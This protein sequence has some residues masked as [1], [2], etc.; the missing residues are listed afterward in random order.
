M[1]CNRS[2]WP[3]WPRGS[4]STAAIAHARARCVILAHRCALAGRHVSCRSNAGP[5]SRS[6][7]MSGRGVRSSLPANFGLNDERR[8]SRLRPMRSPSASGP[9]SGW[10]SWRQARNSPQRC[11]PTGQC[12]AHMF[13][14]SSE[15]PHWST[16]RPTSWPITWRCEQ[17]QRGHKQRR[18]QRKLRHGQRPQTLRPAQSCVASSSQSLGIGLPPA[19]AK[20]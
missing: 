4:S 1:A 18:P 7:R 19:S 9:S 8:S 12:P 11:C 20:E 15:R 6:P 10:P 14:L 3:R 16:S 13:S 17:R 5:C 2:C